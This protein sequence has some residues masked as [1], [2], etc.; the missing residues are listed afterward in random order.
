VRNGRRSVHWWSEEISDLRK[1][2]VKARRRL[3]KSRQKST[4]SDIDLTNYKL[5]KKALRAAI[6]KA[7]GKAWNELILTIDKD[8][9]GLPYKLVLNKLRRTSPTLSETLDS[10]VLNQLLDTLFP[11]IADSRAAL[12]QQEEWHEEW[13][14]LMREVEAFAISR[15]VRNAAPGPDSIKAGVWKCVPQIVVSHLAELFTVSERVSFH[16]PGNGPF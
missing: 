7:K 4:Q 3:T 5:A 12:G 15:D 14:V 11:V 16:P 2:A 1:A 8:P 13:R 9:W 10:T 6:K